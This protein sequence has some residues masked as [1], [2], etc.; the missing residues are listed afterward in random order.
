MT[1]NT[2]N[3]WHGPLESRAAFEA[4]QD[5]SLKK[6]AHFALEPPVLTDKPELLQSQ[7]WQMGKYLPAA[8]L[9]LGRYNPDT[10]ELLVYGEN[11]DFDEIRK[12]KG[13]YINPGPTQLTGEAAYERT[14]NS[15]HKVD[16]LPSSH[17]FNVQAVGTPQEIDAALWDKK[18]LLTSYWNID[19][20]LGRR[21]A[22]CIGIPDT[23]RTEDRDSIEWGRHGAI[24]SD[25]DPLS[26]IDYQTYPFR[27]ADAP[28]ISASEEAVR[29]LAGEEA[30][31][32]LQSYGRVGLYQHLLWTDM[33]QLLSG[34]NVG[35]TQRY[36]N[37][38]DGS[39]CPVAYRNYRMF[40][41]QQELS[42]YHI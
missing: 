36:S 7:L 35:Q 3:V 39:F 22:G 30:V 34:L 18:C 21:S 31:S 15:W 38:A 20:G 12:A 14:I 19:K 5:E 23:S 27:D 37:F 33:G 41:E 26:D 24:A 4:F 28:G 13:T 9:G 8:I 1:S 42:T 11:T 17:R 2:A 25:G 10:T 32:V 40:L 16:G 6:L 29:E